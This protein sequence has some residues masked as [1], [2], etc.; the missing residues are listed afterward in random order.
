MSWQRS[1]GGDPWGDGGEVKVK[2][3][4]KSLGADGSEYAGPASVALIG[5]PGEQ[6]EGVLWEEEQYAALAPGR[7]KKGG[8]S[9][10]GFG[11]PHHADYPSQYQQ[12]QVGG[13]GRAGGG[14]G[15]GMGGMKAQFQLPTH[16]AVRLPPPSLPDSDLYLHRC[17][18]YYKGVEEIYEGDMLESKRHGLGVHLYRNGNVYRGGFKGDKEHGRGALWNESGKVVFEGDF[19]QGKITGTGT[20]RWEDGSHYTGEFSSNTRSGWGTYYFPS[21][22]TYA[23]EWKEGSFW[24]KGRFTFGRTDEKEPGSEYYDGEWLNGQRHGKGSLKLD[25]YEYVGQW[26]MDKI[27]GRGR[28]TYDDKSVF[29]GQFHLGAREGRG[30]VEWPNGATY[31]GRFRQDLIEGVGTC[32]ILKSVVADSLADSLADSASDSVKEEE[33]GSS[34]GGGSG[35]GDEDQEFIIPICVSD[36]ENIHQRAGFTSFGG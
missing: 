1:D 26:A 3:R 30:T 19:F 13:G 17:A 14:G 34:S 21:G 36:L 29:D 33:V 25:D 31:E 35:G 24:G 28:A 18:H 16:Q 6:Q 9:D 10:G 20:Y 5:L 4:S 11:N 7:K 23:G 15:G 2:R 8:F 12:L 27:E 32:T 22:A